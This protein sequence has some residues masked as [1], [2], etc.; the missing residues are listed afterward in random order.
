M[1]M[2]F[3]KEI[4]EKP[5]LMKAAYSFIDRVYIHLAQSESEWIV[6]WK[7]KEGSDLAPD[8]FENALVQQQLRL[9]LIRESDDVRRILL[10]RAMASTLIEKPK[11][12]SPNVIG[13]N[14]AN[15]ILRGWF[16]EQ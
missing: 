12:I 14:A 11:V 13:E 3:D 2:R 4:Y 16:D 8:E 1:E 10:G 15:D 7:S 5:A 9:Q 6:S